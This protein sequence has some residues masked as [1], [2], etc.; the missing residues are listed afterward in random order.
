[1]TLRP[2]SLACRAASFHAF[3]LDTGP[4]RRRVTGDQLA[5]VIQ[6]VTH[7]HVGLAVISRVAREDLFQRFFKSQFLH[8]YDAAGEAAGAGGCAAR[9]DLTAQPMSSRPSTTPRT[10]CSCFV[11]RFTP[12]V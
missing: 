9:Y 5:G 6:R 11:K 4:G 2:R 3:A 12:T 1:A 7:E 10:N 8:V